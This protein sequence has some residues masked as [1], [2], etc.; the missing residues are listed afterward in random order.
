LLQESCVYIT[1]VRQLK[2]L[3]RFQGRAQ[4]YLML[5]KLNISETVRDT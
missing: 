5:K 3:P 2:R 4:P 1:A